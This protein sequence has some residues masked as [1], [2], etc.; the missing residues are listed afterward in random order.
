MLNCINY[1]QKSWLI[2]LL[3]LEL[4]RDCTGGFFIF[5]PL[6]RLSV[7]SQSVCFSLLLESFGLSMTANRIFACSQ[8]C[9]FC[10]FI[11]FSCI[12]SLLLNTLSTTITKSLRLFLH[13]LSTVCRFFLISGAVW[14]MKTRVT[15]T[16]T[17]SD[18]GSMGL[19]C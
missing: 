11:C 15:A 7:S 18:S 17:S 19:C 3:L 14:I 5:N 9:C 2:S 4:H 1:Q 16:F 6:P 13:N 8:V 12:V 10:L